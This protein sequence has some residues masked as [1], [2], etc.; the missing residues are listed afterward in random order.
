MLKRI[1]VFIDAENISFQHYPK[2]QDHLR[3]IGTIA[4]QRIYGDFSRPNLAGW[5][6]V[7]LKHGIKTIHQ[8]QTGKNSAD[9]ELMMDAI[10]MVSG[11][12]DIDSFCIVSSDAD[13]GQLC[14]RLRNHGKTV[15]GF[16]EEKSKPVYRNYFSEFVVLT[17]SKAKSGQALPPEKRN[18]TPIGQIRGVSSAWSVNAFP[19]Q[20]DMAAPQATSAGGAQ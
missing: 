18:A 6:D 20:T 19:G 10:E 12:T 14:L 17:L 9:Q 5:K 11:Q 8:Y 15:I 7:I 1:A 4:C 2:I 13:F 3:R 16:G